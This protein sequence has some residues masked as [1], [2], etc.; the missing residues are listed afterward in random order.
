MTRPTRLQHANGTQWDPSTSSSSF[1]SKRSSISSCL[2]CAS[3]KGCFSPDG[4]FVGG[5]PHL[6]IGFPIFPT[7]ILRG[8]VGFREGSFAGEAPLPMIFWTL[9]IPNHHART[10]K[11]KTIP[12]NTRL[13][14]GWLPGDSKWPFHPLVGGHLQPLFQ[15][16]RF[17]TI[18]K[19]VFHRRIARWIFLFTNNYSQVKK[20]GSGNFTHQVMRGDPSGCEAT[21]QHR[22]S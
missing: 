1:R 18:P 19:K 11:K 6:K 7:S 21:N 14:N 15:G 20:L 12:F 13:W 3:K 2:S 9:S 4:L 16:S 8:S 5:Y 22:G 10:G 17:F